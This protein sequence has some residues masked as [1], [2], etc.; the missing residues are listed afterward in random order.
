LECFVANLLENK[1]RRERQERKE[2][3]ARTDRQQVFEHLLQRRNMNLFNVVRIEFDTVIEQVPK[4]LLRDVDDKGVVV[5]AEARHR[6][7]SFAGGVLEKL[8]LGA[9]NR[10]TIDTR[11]LEIFR[12]DKVESLKKGKSEM[13]G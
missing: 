11:L 4:V 3:A 5:I 6:T 2:K 9:L 12:W 1:E 7:T 13:K 10:I 8:I